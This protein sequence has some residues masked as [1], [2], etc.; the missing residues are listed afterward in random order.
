MTLT[1]FNN[2]KPCQ[3]VVG[4]WHNYWVNYCWPA[5][6][7]FKA[8]RS[9]CNALRIATLKAVA[10][11]MQ[12]LG[13]L[14]FR[15]ATL[16]L[17]QC[18]AQGDCAFIMQRSRR[19]PSQCIASRW[20]LFPLLHHDHFPKRHVS[21]SLATSTWMWLMTAM[22]LVCWAEC[23]RMQPRGRTRTSLLLLLRRNGSLWNILNGLSQTGWIWFKIHHTHMV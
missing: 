10:F 7:R 3:D 11:T 18:N 2:Q 6:H 20:M 9:Y 15:T 13:Q 17:P 21:V 1:K 5:M 12:R 14:L 19:P 22:E 8:N 16:H 23:D 4:Y